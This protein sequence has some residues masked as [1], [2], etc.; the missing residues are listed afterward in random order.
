MVFFNGHVDPKEKP[1]YF[2]HHKAR[3]ISYIR[4]PTTPYS[5]S[6]EMAQ[7]GTY[8]L[9]VMDMAISSPEMPP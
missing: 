2:L 5:S 3:L 4:A 8:V 7:R 6:V 9:V 1:Q